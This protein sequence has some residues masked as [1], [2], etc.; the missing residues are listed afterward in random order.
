MSLG[1]GTRAWNREGKNERHEERTCR[2][3]DGSDMSR[4]EREDNTKVFDLRIGEPQLPNRKDAGRR[5][6][7]GRKR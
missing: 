7:G 6:C 3:G 4:G 2:I 1:N 5:R